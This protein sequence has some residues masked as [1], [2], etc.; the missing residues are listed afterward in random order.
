MTI[1]KGDGPHE[2]AS[3][4]M[5]TWQSQTEQPMEKPMKNQLQSVKLCYSEDVWG[6][7]SALKSSREISI[8][9]TSHV[10]Q[11]VK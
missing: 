11:H 10:Q 8:R 6:S 9:N 5:L 3:S 4:H 1:L 7:L 2:V